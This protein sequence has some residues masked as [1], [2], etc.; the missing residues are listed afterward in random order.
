[1]GMVLSVA[2]ALARDGAASGT[3]TAGGDASGFAAALR[4]LGECDARFGVSPT[5]RSYNT[6]LRAAI[7]ADATWRGRWP[8]IDDDA[9]ERGANGDA[10]PSATADAAD[11]AMA[12][13]AVG[14]GADVARAVVRAMTDPDA[15]ARGVAPDDRTLNALVR[16]VCCRYEAPNEANMEDNTCHLSNY[17]VN[18]WSS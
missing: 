2:E 4:L 3:T 12:E 17:S 6:V 5:K 7:G 1:M 10:P 16:A 9:D 8:P 11:A 15:R 13:A 18:K 14:P